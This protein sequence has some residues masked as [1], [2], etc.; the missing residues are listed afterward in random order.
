MKCV[1]QEVTL[2]G[3]FPVVLVEAVTEDEMGV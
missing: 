2:L 1:A 3:N